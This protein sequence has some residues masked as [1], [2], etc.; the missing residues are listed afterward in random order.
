MADLLKVCIEQK[1]SDLHLA[2]GRPP[3]LRING[4]LRDL[5][6]PNLNPPEC[7]R[8]IY[9]ILNDMQK[10]KFEQNKELDFSLSITNMGRF[11][12]N[13]HLQRGTVAAAFRMIDSKIRSFE[14]L[15]LPARVMEH[16]SRR[17]NGF[18]LITGPTG[19]GKST[20]LASMIDLINRERDCHIITVEDP[21]EYLHPH[22]RAL[23][24]QREINE[25]TFSFTNALKYAL[26]QDPDVLMIG[27]MRDL[28]TISA[29]LTAA[30][31]GH[32][33]FSTLHTVSAVATMDRV[34]DVFP[35]HQQEQVRIQL[36]GVIEGVICQK[37][38]PSTRRGR[39]IAY[40]VMI[41]TDAIRNQVR[42]GNTHM[43]QG[44]I[45]SGGKWNMV[46]MDRSIMDLY[47][48]GR[49]SRET[50]LLACNK[51]EEMRRQIG[52]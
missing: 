31:T 17:P 8:L 50:A 9:G 36:A 48:A 21:I 44:T 1:A 32:L 28:D 38:L 4:A 46:T 39:E 43:I 3:V 35:P 49:I 45:E 25:D 14:D 42:E 51:P 26:R 23:I 10:Q 13:I 22:K 2:V 20:S 18:V 19:S 24:E 12:A 15:N 33:V 27:E 11:R 6:G 47:R 41:A 30:E 29:A 52:G 34:I 5:S 7:R 40:E 16:L 37:L